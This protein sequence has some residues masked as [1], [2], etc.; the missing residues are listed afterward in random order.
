MKKEVKDLELK[1]ELTNKIKKKVTIGKIDEV[2]G[3]HELETLFTDSNIEDEERVRRAWE[4]LHNY[5]KLTLTDA[6]KNEIENYSKLRYEREKIRHEVE[7]QENKVAP[8]YIFNYYIGEYKIKM[9]RVLNR[10]KNAILVGF[11][12]GFLTYINKEL[13]RE[14]LWYVFGLMIEVRLVLNMILIGLMKAEGDY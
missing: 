8:Y 12:Y 4:L 5:L 7:K 2:L 3:G 1:I 6:E 10:T 14:F 13:Q 9:H 11:L